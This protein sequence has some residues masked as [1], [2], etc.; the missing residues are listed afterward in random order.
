M[1]KTDGTLLRPWLVP[2]VRPVDLARQAGCSHQYVYAVLAGHKPASAR[3][4]DA[5]DALGLPT[6]VIFG[7]RGDVA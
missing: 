5:A 3:L 7:S 1:L 2:R 6:D 4:I